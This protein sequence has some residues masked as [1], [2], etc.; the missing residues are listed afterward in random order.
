[1]SAL[2]HAQLWDVQSRLAEFGLPID[3]L[4]EAAQ[5]GHLSLVSCSDNDPPATRGYMVWALTLRRLRE[6]LIPS[7]WKRDDSQNFSR[8]FSEKQKISII[9]ATGDNGTGRSH[10]HP[11]TKSPKGQLT[12]Q[13]VY[14]NSWQGTFKGFLPEEETADRPLLE[15]ETWIFLVYITATEVRAELS[16]PSNIEDGNILAWQERILLPPIEVDPGA[17]EMNPDDDLGPEFEVAV[18]RKN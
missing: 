16:L 10:L 11:R 17:L 9:V 14:R 2:I 4:Q 6:K 15:Y 5:A 18:R 8:T 7:G 1:M 12:E 3:A 13:A